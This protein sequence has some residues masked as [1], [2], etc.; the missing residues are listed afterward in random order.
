[1]QNHEDFGLAIG[2]ADIYAALR[3]KGI[4]NNDLLD[5]K[6]KELAKEGII[7]LFTLDDFDE[8]LIIA[9]KII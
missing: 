5:Y 7:K 1:M 8:N 2:Y 6:L 3:D 4:E 9:V